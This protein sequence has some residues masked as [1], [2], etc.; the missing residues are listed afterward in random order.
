[1]EVLW[2]GLADLRKRDLRMRST[3][4]LW[5]FCIYGMV[6]FMEPF[7]RLAGFLPIV[8]RGLIYAALI[9]SGEFAT[10]SLLKRVDLCPWDYSHVRYHVKGLI[11]WDYVPAWAVAGLF[12]ER[13]YWM[14]VA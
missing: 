8:V 10:G 5:M 7:F 6:V 1:M 11:R 4:S 2:T 14:L 13:V 12:F 9:M 3:T